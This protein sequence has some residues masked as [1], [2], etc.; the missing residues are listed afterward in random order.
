M[1][2]PTPA[3]FDL[4]SMFAGVSFPEETVDVFTDAGVA[5]NYSRL[6]EEAVRAVTREDAEAALADIEARQK[7][8]V[9]SAEKH[10]YEIHLRGVMQDVLDALTTKAATEFPPK[11]S[12]PQIPG[13]PAQV[14]YSDEFYE[15]LDLNMW[16]TIIQKIVA[17]NGAE[18][19]KP[20]LEFVAG[21]KAKLPLS[22]RSKVNQAIRGF[23]EKSKSGFESIV[24][25]R[26]FLSKAS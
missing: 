2:N 19:I 24:Q 4:A 9:E 17:P 26:D 21:L 25:E 18:V 16:Y 7:A 13:F 23:A 1:E 11:K 15:S 3:T 12:A 6:A 14:E 5:Y 22:E 10:R 20:D 8:L